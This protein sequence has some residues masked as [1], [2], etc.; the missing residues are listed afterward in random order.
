[1]PKLVYIRGYEG[2]GKEV[3]CQMTIDTAPAGTVEPIVDFD[4]SYSANTITLTK[5]SGTAGQITA[6]KVQAKVVS[7]DATIGEITASTIAVTPGSKQSIVKVMI[8]GIERYV[9]VAA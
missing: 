2:R 8:D 6:D 3:L 4:A 5:K 9:V 1:M 7:G